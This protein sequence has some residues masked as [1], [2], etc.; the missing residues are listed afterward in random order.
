MKQNLMITS[1][2]HFR[3][4]LTTRIIMRDVMIA[5]LPAVIASVLIFGWRALLVSAVC[6]VASVGFEYLYGRFVSKSYTIMDLSA[7]VTGL[8]LALNLPVSIPLWMAVIGCFVAIVIVKQLFGGLGKN[9]ANPAIAARIVLMLSFTTAM[10]QWVL[11]ISQRWNGELTGATPL[12]MASIPAEKIPG[13]LQLFLGNVGGSLGETSKLA[14][15]LGF[16]YL[17]IRRHVRITGPLAFMGTVFLF[18]W[19]LGMD[20]LYQLLSGGVILGACFMVTDYV[21]TPTTDLGKLIFGIGGGIITV[22]IR[23]YGSAPEGVSFA[24]LLM[25]ICT[26]H[27]DR[28]THTRPFGIPRRLTKQSVR[29]AMVRAKQSMLGPT[30]ILAAICLIIT[31]ALSV[32]YSS[33]H[34]RIAEQEESASF[35]ARNRML[36]AAGGEFEAVELAQA[37]EGMLEAYKAS[38]GAGYVFKAQSNGYKAQVPVMVALDEKGEILA[39]EMLPNSESPGIGSRVGEAAYLQKYTGQKNGDQVESVSG[40]TITTK[41]LKENLRIVQEAYNLIQGGK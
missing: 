20:P 30:I 10:T 1:S 31:A 41:A 34:T 8:L 13:Y 29:E 2:P 6:T 25:N 5:L 12:A 22:L 35:E 27:I 36:P 24:I 18:S 7:A 4:H 14:L 15:L 19:A 33:T 17:L 38:N 32:T 39:I 40:A 11:P 28:L 37:P 21:T 3:T 23:S 9:F 26:P 16:A